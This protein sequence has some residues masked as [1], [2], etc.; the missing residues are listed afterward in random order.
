MLSGL[1]SYWWKLTDLAPCMPPTS[2]LNLRSQAKV[3]NFAGGHPGPSRAS[4]GGDGDGISTELKCCIEVPDHRLSS[5]IHSCDLVLEFEEEEDEDCEG[6]D[7]GECSGEGCKYTPEPI[8]ASELIEH[9]L[10]SY[11]NSAESFA[12]A[13][14]VDRSSVDDLYRDLLVLIGSIRAR[15]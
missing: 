14:G 11:D 6:E 15:T 5:Q 12:E 8:S 9:L 10:D 7:C 1:P 4:G 3:P 13:R 2:E